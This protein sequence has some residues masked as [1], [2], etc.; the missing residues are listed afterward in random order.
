MAVGGAGDE[1]ATARAGLAAV[2]ARLAEADRRLADLLGAAHRVAVEA[3][4]GLRAI[5]DEIDAAV[6]ARHTETSAAGRDF[7]RFLLAKNREITGI[8]TA[9][10]VEA[11]AKTVA[12][13]DLARL[14]TG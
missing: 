9:A 7:G 1:F 5:Q 14:Y 12:L 11:H 4:A 6:A 2:D 8:I 13:Q 3:I 10:R